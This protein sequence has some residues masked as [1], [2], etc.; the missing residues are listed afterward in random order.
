MYVKREFLS[1]ISNLNPESFCGKYV[2]MLAFKV[3]SKYIRK[4]IRKFRTAELNL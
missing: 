1:I 3:T 4:N 2:L